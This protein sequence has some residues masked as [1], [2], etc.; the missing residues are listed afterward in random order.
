MRQEMHDYQQQKKIIEQL[1]IQLR[2]CKEQMKEDKQLLAELTTYRSGANVDLDERDRKI[3]DI[4]EKKEQKIDD[5]QRE[6][7]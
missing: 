4:V 6:I 1:Q 2:Q 7:E 3:K 5:L